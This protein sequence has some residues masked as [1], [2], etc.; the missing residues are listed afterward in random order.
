MCS[1]EKAAN[2]T[3]CQHCTNRPTT[4][5][6]KCSGQFD[7]ATRL[8]SEQRGRKNSVAARAS[9]LL[10]IWSILAVTAFM[11]CGCG[12]SA[13]FNGPGDD[14]PVR[15]LLE[16]RH[17][18]VV[19]QKW[20]LSCGAAALD[21]L[22]RYEWG[23]PATEQ[24]IALGLMS[25]KEYIEHPQLVQIREGFSLL[26]LKRY[27]ESHGYKGIGL[28]DMDFND[29]IQYAPIM[30]PINANGYNHFVI[31]RGIY[32]NRVLLAD[33][34]WGERTMTIDGFQHLWLDFGKP[35]GKVGFAVERANGS[36][37][38]SKLVPRPADFV[39]LD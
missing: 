19:I 11:L 1:L 22:L 21:I 9:R 10:S 5:A 28:G 37:P 32:G 4:I 33:P 23:D 24:D 27:V 34:A 16:M 20:D 38:V 13:T 3:E 12:G 30:V 15:S 18:D 39:T 31:F 35:I 17:Q 29:L 14:P 6:T 7:R 8:S 2:A 36:S 25:R 26:D